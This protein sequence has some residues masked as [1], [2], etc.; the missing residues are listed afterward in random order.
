MLFSSQEEV[1]L[2][3]DFDHNQV[4]FFCYSQLW[5]SQKQG[6]QL[7]FISD[8]SFCIKYKNLKYK[9]VSIFQ[10]FF[11]LIVPLIYEIFDI[12]IRIL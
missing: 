11:V 4:K 6:F 7:Y 3:Q 12:H 2:Y 10:I 5:K 8:F 1:F 9:N